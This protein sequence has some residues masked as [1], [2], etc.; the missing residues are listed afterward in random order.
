MGI[1]HLHRQERGTLFQRA[2]WKPG[3]TQEQ[4]S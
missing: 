2:A 1:S 4:G 3:T